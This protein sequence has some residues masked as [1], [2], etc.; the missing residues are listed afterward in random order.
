[1]GHDGTVLTASDP[2]YSAKLYTQFGDSWRISQSESLFDYRP[3]EST[4]TFTNLAVPYHLVSAATLPASVRAAAERV[5]RALGVFSQPLLDDCILDVG[6]T[7]NPQYAMGEALI[8][9]AGVPA[10]GQPAPGTA[11]GGSIAIGQ[12]VSGTITA[13][14]SQVNYTFTGP[15]NDIVYLEAKTPCDSALDWNLL[16]PDGSLKNSNNACGDI[17]REVLSAAGSWTVQVKS[18]SSTGPY[19]FVVLSVPHVVTTPITMGQAINGAITQIG[20]WYDYTFTATSGEVVDLKHQGACNNNLQWALN[21]PDGSQQAFSS[22]CG[23]VGREVLG[24]SGTW[25]VQVY[26]FQ[27][28]TATGPY[29]FVVQ[30]G[31]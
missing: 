24:Q 6:E 27:N 1:M 10:G 8:A 5:C 23:D 19:T 12:T 14:N 3:G 7:G 2:A 13:P 26:A 4:A 20:A 9:A 30:S 17:G 25:T 22:G 11:P 16:R 28:S 31:Q 15:A 21:R 29:G 18:N